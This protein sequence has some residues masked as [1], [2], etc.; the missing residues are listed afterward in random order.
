[1]KKISSNLSALYSTIYV[2]NG[3]HVGEN[4]ELDLEDTAVSDV[5]WY[6][7]MLSES[8]KASLL[9]GTLRSFTVPFHVE[10]FDDRPELDLENWDHVNECSIEVYA[11]LVFSG[12]A[13]SEEQMIVVD[14][15]KG[16]YGVFIAYKGLGT[17]DEMGIEGNDEYYAFL[18]PSAEHL[19]KQVVKQ[20]PLPPFLDELPS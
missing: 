15:P 10:I 6:T 16:I 20:W 18:W 17:I 12:V 1:M 9:I 8:G 7:T 13:D 11:K 19:N 2:Q 14:L 5:E 3:L 4:L